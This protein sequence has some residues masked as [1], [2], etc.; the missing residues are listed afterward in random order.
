MNELYIHIY[1]GSVPPA[2]LDVAIILHAKKQPSSPF[3]CSILI[4][5]IPELFAHIDFTYTKAVDS[6]KILMMPTNMMF[7]YVVDFKRIKAFQHIIRFTY[8]CLNVCR[9]TRSYTD[10]GLACNLLECDF[11]KQERNT[12]RKS[13]TRDFHVAK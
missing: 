6:I 4:S 13:S 11:P 9:L 1:S 12:K 8:I 7:F 3:K 5:H 2:C 10:S